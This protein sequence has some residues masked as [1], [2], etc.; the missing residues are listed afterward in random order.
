VSGLKERKILVGEKF[1]GEKYSRWGVCV[2]LFFK[3]EKR[4]VIL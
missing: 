4:G 2:L 3:V 1:L